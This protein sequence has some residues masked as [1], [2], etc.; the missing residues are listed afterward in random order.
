MFLKSVHKFLKSQIRSR[1]SRGLFLAA[2]F[3]SFLCPWPSRA[4]QGTLYLLAGTPSG[5]GSPSQYE[6]EI[7]K[8]DPGRGYSLVRRIST[9]K[10]GIVFIQ[11]D[12]K[13]GVVAVGKPYPAIRAVEMIS[14]HNPETQLADSL[15]FSVIPKT[16]WTIVPS[17]ASRR[18]S[19]E[20]YL[21]IMPPPEYLLLSERLLDVGTRSMLG[22]YLMDSGKAEAD[23]YVDVG[24]L[25]DA[26]TAKL[27]LEVIPA[28]YFSGLRVQGQF[29]FAGLHDNDTTLIQSVQGVW[30]LRRMRGPSDMPLTLPPPPDGWPSAKTLWR[31]RVHDQDATLIEANPEKALPAGDAANVLTLQVASA[32][33]FRMYLSAT[34]RWTTLPISGSPRGVRHMNRWIMGVMAEEAK[35]RPSAGEENVRKTYLGRESPPRPSTQLMMTMD[36][37]YYPGE[38]FIIST[39]SGKIWTLKTDQGDSEVL[40]VQDDIVY[41]R[42]NDRIMKCTIQGDFLSA[43]TELAKAEE[44]RDVHIA[45][46]GR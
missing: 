36:S 32:G 2:C 4:A 8:I 9:S 14:M 44:L 35:G 25:L 38:L 23:S 11:P 31:L 20:G 13:T 46:V 43:P 34:K 1:S 26:S 33:K 42:V 39:D 6:A 29:G 5:F 30:T 12:Y 7:Y 24:F 28:G 17:T 40:L 22:L 45:F 10:D 16:A 3:A 41:F 21:K 19:K 18:R 27:Q 15:D 37:I